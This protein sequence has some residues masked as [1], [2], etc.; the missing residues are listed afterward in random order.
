[1]LH[2]LKERLVANY[3]LISLMRQLIASQQIQFNP[4]ES[5]RR[6]ECVRESAKVGA[7]VT[8]LQP[9]VAAGQKAKGEHQ[10]RKGK[11]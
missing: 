11:K 9:L 1:M 6:I 4:V 10:E 8:W 2:V 7:E 3:E 5:V